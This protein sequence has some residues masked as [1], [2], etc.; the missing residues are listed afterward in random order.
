MY[1]DEG[2]CFLSRERVNINR[3]LSFANPPG[4]VGEPTCG[5]DHTFMLP[6][7]AR[8]RGLML[9]DVTYRQ[10]QLPQV[11]PYIIFD[12]RGRVLHCWP[13]DYTPGHF[14]IEEKARELLK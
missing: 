12:R 8:D 1:E 2:C 14:E 11:D 5:L 3:L 4:L 9:L 10:P 7:Q 13:K 6:A